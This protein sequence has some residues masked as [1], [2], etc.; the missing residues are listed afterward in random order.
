MITVDQVKALRQKTGAGMIDCKRALIESD[1]IEE[2]AVWY[3]RNYP[4]YV[5][6][7]WWRCKD[8]QAWVKRFEEEKSKYLSAKS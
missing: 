2:L 7:D 1:G 8:G 6:M 3:L 5:P 4:T